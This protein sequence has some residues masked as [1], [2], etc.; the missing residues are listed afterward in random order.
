MHYERSEVGGEELEDFVKV[1]FENI[2]GSK[3]LEGGATSATTS[4]DQITARAGSSESLDPLLLF[5][6]LKH[7]L[8][9]ASVTIASCNC[10]SF[11][12]PFP[13]LP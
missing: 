11:I 3:V 9:S 7:A 4:V 6:E 12:S 2:P 8:I 13:N 1:A 5:Q 10:S